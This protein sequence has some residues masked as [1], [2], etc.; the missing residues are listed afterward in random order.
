MGHRIR[1]FD[2]TGFL[3]FHEQADGTLVC[4]HRDV[5]VCDKC[6]EDWAD[7]ISDVYGQFYAV[8]PEEMAEIK[9]EDLA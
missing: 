6:A 4:R 9:A 7:E 8:P 5:S 2:G 1:T 3:P